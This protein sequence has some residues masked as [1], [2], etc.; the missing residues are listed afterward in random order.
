[1]RLSHRFCIC[2]L[3]NTA[4]QIELQQRLPSPSPT[5]D[6]IRATSRQLKAAPPAK[7][8][9]ATPMRTGASICNER[10]G[11]D[12]NLMYVQANMAKFSDTPLWPQSAAET[13]A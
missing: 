6:R 10:N 7:P 9:F 13:R 8:N 12:V 1:M 11:S 2:H 5:S 4:S 3:P